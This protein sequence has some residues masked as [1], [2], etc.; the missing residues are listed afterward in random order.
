MQLSIFGMGRIKF[1]RYL[2]LSVD[3]GDRLSRFWELSSFF[4]RR[5]IG[6]YSLCKRMRY[7]ESILSGGCTESLVNPCSVKQIL[8]K[9]N[10]TAANSCNCAVQLARAVS[11][12]SLVTG[13]SSDGKLSSIDANVLMS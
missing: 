5:K 8:Q 6:S 11:V 10:R 1:L 7:T 13:Q 2:G 4:S 9:F 3:G 12:W